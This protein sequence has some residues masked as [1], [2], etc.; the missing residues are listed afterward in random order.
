MN[1]ITKYLTPYNHNVGDISRIKYI[2]IHYVGALGGAKA[3]CKYYATA[4]RNASAHYYVGFDGEIW[5]SVED[6]N[7]AWHCGAKA[8]KHPECR[9]A[10]SIGIEMCVRNNGNLADTSKDWYFEDATVASTI[11]LTKWLMK[12]YNISPDHVI[13][14]HD[15]TGK[16]C[17]NPYVYNQGK[18]TWNDFKKAISDPIKKS[19][20][21]K[22]NDKWY[23]YL[24]NTGTRITNN[25][26]KDTTD[27]WAWFDGNG[28][29]LCNQWYE[30]E[31]NWYY[32]GS[33]CYMCSSQWI[34]YNSNQ[35][36]LTADGTM[37]KSAYIKSKDPKSG[38]YYWVNEDGVWESEWD[39]STP[40]LEK[41]KL[42]E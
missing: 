34:E 37:A 29:A 5:Q 33:N 31:Y 27:H 7:I 10:N 20:W 14:H 12:K 24:G 13:R 17:P 32:F 22:E 35:Y 18:H 25:W 26:Y 9:N 36:Y 19:G 42:V 23:F 30:Y 11:E 4:N 6:N 15:V 40:D 2:V 28:Q 8:Y 3:N 41:Y 38:M 16:I 39:T 21:H 1:K